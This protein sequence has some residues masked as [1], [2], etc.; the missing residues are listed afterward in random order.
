MKSARCILLFCFLLATPI[1]AQTIT[2]GNCNSSYVNGTYMLTLSGRGISSSGAFTGSFQANGTATFDGL[3]RVTFTGTDNTNTG[4]GQSFNYS[5]TYTMSSNCLGTVTLTSGSSATFTLVLWDL[6]TTGSA[7]E[8]S[9]AGADSNYVYSGTIDNFQPAV[10]AT[11]TLSGPFVYTASGFTLSSAGQQNGAEDESGVLQFDGQGKVTA[12]YTVSG[13]GTNM[14]GLTSTGTYS[15]NS[16]CLATATLNESGANGKTDTLTFAINGNDAN[17]AEVLESNSG[18]VRTGAVHAAFTNPGESIVNV[19]SSAVDS[20][21]PGSIFA[22]YGVN[23]ATGNMN[24]TT[25]PLPTTLRTTSVT[26]N[27]IQA[28]LFFVSSGQINAQM[29]LEVPG[30][31]V[32][33][34]VVMNTGPGG[35]TSNAAGVYVPATGTPGQILTCSPTNNRACVVNADGNVNTGSDGANVGDEVVLYFVGGGPV[36]ASGTLADGKASPSGLSPITGTSSVTVGGQQATIKYIGLTPGSVGLYQVNFIVP[37]L[38][39]GT[40]GVVITIAGQASDSASM[41]VSN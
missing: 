19:G 3:A 25:L 38:A 22:L 13:P 26:V 12:T 17:A 9:L 18:F 33:T 11:S 34:V 27:G 5:G 4:S 30:N 15:V 1:F 14:T 37:Q 16:N 6:T 31:S 40:Y 35:S 39:K 2:G 41:T 8:G 21:P 28:P 7:R 29:P 32:A 24:A 23:L 36:T 10:C 20:T